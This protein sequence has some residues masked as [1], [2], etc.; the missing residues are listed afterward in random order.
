MT[1]RRPTF[2]QRLTQALDLAAEPEARLA[3]AEFLAGEGLFHE[4]APVAETL[5]AQPATATGGRR[6]AMI[7]RQFDRWG[8]Q[9][10]LEPFADP[11]GQPD[12]AGL[13]RSGLL[14]R[15]EGSRDC[16]IVFLGSASQ[17][18]VSLYLLER[19]LPP[20]RHILFLKDP[21]QMSF[22]FGTPALGTCHAA[23]VPSLH[24]FLDSL[25]VHRFH[26]LGTS[27]G[28]FAALHFG[29][30]AGA[31]GVLTLSPATTLVPLL[32]RIRAAAD[33]ARREELDRRQP[34]LPDIADVLTQLHRPSCP[35][36]LVH[37][38]DHAEDGAQCDRLRDWPGI[39][40]HPIADCAQHDTLGSLI[41]SG[42][43]SDLFK[44]VFDAG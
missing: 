8:L 26:V 34:G 33:P 30:T 2:E 41:T 36:L 42:G 22:A 27:S 23:I 29:L 3:A 12:R 14:L 43:I 4:M 38:A 16:V 5:A 44:R 11:Q 32:A 20:D 40:L 35:V 19:V 6:L 9:D 10:R 21:D 15:R 1:A 39:T 28:G 25:G 18:W 24:R 37:A 13:T 7:C 17:Y 31:A